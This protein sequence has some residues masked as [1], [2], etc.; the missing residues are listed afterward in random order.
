MGLQVLVT[1]GVFKDD[2]FKIYSFV[3]RRSIF[4]MD[5]MVMGRCP[6]NLVAWLLPGTEGDRPIFL[7][8]ALVDMEF[9][10]IL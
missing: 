2:F 3:W 5:N 8:H 10:E 1:W 7:H 9:C 6:V 4:S